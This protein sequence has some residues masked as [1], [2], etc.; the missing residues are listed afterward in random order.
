M[1][2]ADGLRR[3]GLQALAAHPCPSTLSSSN[4][5]TCLQEQQ[6]QQL[7]QAQLQQL[8]A[9]TEAM[10]AAAQMHQQHHHRPSLA[11]HSSMMAHPL[12]SSGMVPQPDLVQQQ[13]QQGSGARGQQH[14]RGGG[15]R[16]QPHGHADADGG[17][18]GNGRRLFPRCKA[19]CRWSLLQSACLG[20]DAPLAVIVPSCKG[21]LAAVM[22]FWYR[23]AWGLNGLGPGLPFQQ[24]QRL[25]MSQQQQQQQH[26]GSPMSMQ[27]PPS[28]AAPP[29]P[30][31]IFGAV[32]QPSDLAAMS[33]AQAR[34]MLASSSGRVDALMH[35]QQHQQGPSTPLQHQ[36]SGSS[37]HH[38]Q[39]QQ[40]SGPCFPSLPDTSSFMVPSYSQAMQQPSGSGMHH[41]QQQQLGLS[42]AAS[43][44]IP[45]GMRG[46]LEGHMGGPGQGGW[47]G[48]GQAQVCHC[49]SAC[50]PVPCMLAY[51]S[52]TSLGPAEVQPDG[53]G[54]ACLAAGLSKGCGSS[55]SN[56]T[57]GAGY[58][59]EQSCGHSSS[60]RGVILA[61]PC[62]GEQ[63]PAATA[64]AVA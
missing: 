35:H 19:P 64:G 11:T 33:T 55:L 18:G 20:L 14:A 49:S 40:P 8:Q 43:L 21:W 50:V 24:Q 29:S 46:P 22:D 17:H 52:F 63:P 27:P 34:P 47:P 36:H 4:S 9:S 31:A 15:A 1:Q 10:Q 60:A 41:Q 42:R 30:S 6:Q 39:Q 37:M 44:G 3:W 2:H 53:T 7:L 38:Q 59:D 26:A 51:C 16:P 57:C 32:R 58:A 23:E 61:A 45:G 25:A 62:F 28:S 12:S 48:G 56:F 5:S 13:Q 54:Y